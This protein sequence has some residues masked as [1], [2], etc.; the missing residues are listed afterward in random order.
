MTTLPSLILPSIDLTY[1]L[2]D[3]HNRNKNVRPRL[4]HLP[5]ILAIQ[6]NVLSKKKGLH[7]SM[8]LLCQSLT[9]CSICTHYDQ[10]PPEV[11]KRLKQTQT[12]RQII[13]KQF[14]H[15]GQG[16][17]APG[18]ILHLPL[19]IILPSLGKISGE[20]GVDVLLHLAH[21]LL[22]LHVTQDQQDHHDQNSLVLEHWHAAAQQAGGNF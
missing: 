17:D 13:T 9:S 11:V 18:N 19:N 1:T 2:F 8:L 14:L 22:P 3:P 15:G 5:W 4:S 6:S 21:H 20:H 16:L 7:P 12:Y 10:L